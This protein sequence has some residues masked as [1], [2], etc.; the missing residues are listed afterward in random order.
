MN[1]AALAS[2][3]VRL[4]VLIISGNPAGRRRLASI[5]ARTFEVVEARHGNEAIVILSTRS[6]DA[7]VLD[8]PLPRLRG[9]DVLAYYQGRYP[10]RSNVIV[11]ADPE[12]FPAIESAAVYTTVAK[13]LDTGAFAAV[14]SE[15][16]RQQ[17]PPVAWPWMEHP[18]VLAAE[19]G[20]QPRQPADRR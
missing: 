19:R 2:P 13:P 4:A 16:A 7:V 8:L 15:C 12:Q 17:F 10:E 3:R 9:V 18:R 6:F 11:T 20:S 1:E 5:G 14:L